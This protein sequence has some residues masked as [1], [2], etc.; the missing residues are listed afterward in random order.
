MVM[1]RDFYEVPMKHVS[2]VKF[3]E[4]TYDE[5]QMGYRF[6]RKYFWQNGHATYEGNLYNPDGSY[7]YDIRGTL[8]LSNDVF[9]NAME[10][11]D[12]EGNYLGTDVE[13]FTQE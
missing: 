11:Y 6:A 3:D 5:D 7:L 2:N 4:Q 8:I 12:A 9:S 13:R 1:T 10:F